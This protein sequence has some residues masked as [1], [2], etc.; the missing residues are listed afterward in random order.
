MVSLGG[1]KIV[2]KALPMSSRRPARH[3][4]AEE[5]ETRVVEE[6]R[7]ARCAAQAVGARATRQAV[8]E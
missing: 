7:G 4:S 8:E 2:A 3:T 5:R 6:M 1:L